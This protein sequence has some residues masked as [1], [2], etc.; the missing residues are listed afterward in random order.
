MNDVVQLSRLS[1]GLVLVGGL[2]V[3]AGL[4]VLRRV[5]AMVPMSVGRRAWLMRTLPVVEALA[6]VGYL[7]VT[8]PPLF[9]S[10]AWGMTAAVAVM[11]L[12]LLVISW[13]ALGDV[14][15]GVM[16]R[17]SG[18]S[19]PGDWVRVG[20]LRGVVRRIGL[21]TVELET[22]HGDQAIIP[23][24]QLA[25][26]PLV[27]APALAGISRHRFSIQLPAGMQ[28][29]RGRELAR[30]AALNCHWSS[31]ARDPDV[32]VLPG[33]ELEVHVFPLDSARGPD[34]EDAVRGALQRNDNGS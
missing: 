29:W 17:A 15:A 4:W 19:E 18:F 31:A 8:L 27:R 5:L 28:A 3:V 23:Y 21:R 12:A 1:L 9:A 30:R 25:K 26:E 22:E 6:F 33:G 14:V 7:F 16:M 24:S 13:F 11:L 20:E 2:G 32:E 10:P 34:I